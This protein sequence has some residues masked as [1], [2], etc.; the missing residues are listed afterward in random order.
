MNDNGFLWD[1]KEKY[2][3]FGNLNF[4]F[5]YHPEK[6]D[7]GRTRV[8][9]I[10]W[11]NDANQSEI[12]QTVELAGLEYQRFLQIQ[13]EAKFKKKLNNKNIIIGGAI[14]LLVGAVAT[15]TAVK[16]VALGVVGAII[17]GAVKTLRR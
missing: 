5:I 4:M 10:L 12:K 11:D 16:A 6:D 14:G 13:T 7:I 1:D 3:S 2:A 15:D 8:A 9:K 17:G